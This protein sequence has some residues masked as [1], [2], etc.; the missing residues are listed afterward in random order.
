MVFFLNT[1]NLIKKINERLM[2]TKMSLVKL[3]DVFI[4]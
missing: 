2:T 3:S 1:L 4:G